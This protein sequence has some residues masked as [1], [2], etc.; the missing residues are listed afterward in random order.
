M[1]SILTGEFPRRDSGLL[2][3]EGSQG[4]LLGKLGLRCSTEIQ[5]EMSHRRMKI[6]RSW[7]IMELDE[8]TGSL[9]K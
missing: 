4:F 9:W 8:M 6:M 3:R 5:T 2:G 1:D 7:K